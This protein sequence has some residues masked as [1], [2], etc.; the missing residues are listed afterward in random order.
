MKKLFYCIIKTQ[1]GQKPRNVLIILENILIN[2][3]FSYRPELLNI[4]GTKNL[5][6]R[7]SIDMIEL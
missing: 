6:N 4:Q 5:I 2:H 7:L 1:I 3:S